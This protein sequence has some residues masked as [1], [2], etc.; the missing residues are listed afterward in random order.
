MAVVRAFGWSIIEFEAVLFQKFLAM[1]APYSLMTED[2]FRKH[3][4][5]MESKGY[6][7]YI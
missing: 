4:K 2:V 6:L 1:S 5:N 7:A 3:L